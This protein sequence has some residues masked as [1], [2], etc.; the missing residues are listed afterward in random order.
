VTDNVKGP[1]S[2]GDRGGEAPIG[3][4]DR[5]LIACQAPSAVP[6]SGRVEGAIFIEGSFTVPPA[7]LLSG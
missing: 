5:K 6:E 4:S 1:F 3:P 7:N 2:L